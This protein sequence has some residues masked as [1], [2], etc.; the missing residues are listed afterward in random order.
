MTR[1]I[2]VTVGVSL[3]TEYVLD[4]EALTI[5]FD[6]LPAPA[7]TLAGLRR[8][9]KKLDSRASGQDDRSFN[10]ETLPWIK[11][12]NSLKD[13]LSALWRHDEIDEQTKHLYSG[14]ELASLMRL[15]KSG[16]FASLA[17]DD[18]LVLLASDTPTGEFCATVIRDVLFE[19]T[20]GTSRLDGRPIIERIS[21]LRPDTGERFLAEGLPGVARKLYEHSRPPAQALLIGS[22]GYKGILPYLSPLSMALKIPLLYLYEDSDDL[23]E[24]RPLPVELKLQVIRDNAK[25]FA[26]ISPRSDASEIRSCS[27]QDFWAKVHKRDRGVLQEMQVLQE[28]GNRIRL[29]PTGVLAW[30]LAWIDDP[31]EL[32]VP[33]EPL[34]GE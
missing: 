6:R 14:A 34:V 2:L 20:I 30:L 25:A 29:S 22:G 27:S 11:I 12:R 10:P 31:E 3:I 26:L 4:K 19:G 8:E 18:R 28:H 24:L 32:E 7:G 15:G 23:L 9:L 33:P 13:S 16:S 17:S 21:G 5:G 1:T